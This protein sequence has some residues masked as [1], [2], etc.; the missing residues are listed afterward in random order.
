MKSKTQ[1]LKQALIVIGLMTGALILVQFV[2]SVLAG[3]FLSDKDNPQLISDATQGTGDVRVLAMDIVNY[4][5]GFL[6]FLAVLMVIYGGILYVTAAGN[7][8][9]AKKA[10]TIIMYA[11]IGIIIILLSYAIVN[12]ILQAATT[13]V[14]TGV[15]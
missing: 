3:G 2:P 11:A 13:T 10:K 5:L 1:I 12:T 4:F 15:Q 14:S 7:E 9:N 8:E 6:G